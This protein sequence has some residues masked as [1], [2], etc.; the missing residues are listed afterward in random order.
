MDVS[1]YVQLPFLE[2]DFST[3]SFSVVV[4]KVNINPKE[5]DIGS[6]G[7]SEQI[8]VP[9]SVTST[10][11]ENSVV[12]TGNSA[13]GVQ[14]KTANSKRKLSMRTIQF[15]MD[16]VFSFSYSFFTIHVKK[17]F[18][19]TNHRCVSTA[20]SIEYRISLVQTRNGIHTKKV[21]SLLYYHIFVVENKTSIYIDPIKESLSSEFPRNLLEM[22]L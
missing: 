4:L 14:Y 9:Y 3:F 21:C 7:V 20:F 2:R 11:T 15:F 5:M 17:R 18:F 10:G 6:G 12:C 22:N 8:N 19:I 16:S 13:D 1:R